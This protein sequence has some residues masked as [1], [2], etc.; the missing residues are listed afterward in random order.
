MTELLEQTTPRDLP[1]VDV[2]ALARTARR[3]T[4]RRRAV[5][6]TAAVAL[7]VAP[8]AVLT[9][10]RDEGSTGITTDPSGRIQPSDQ[11]EWHRASDPP[12]A[13]R[14][15]ALA[16]RTE[17]GRLVVW[18]GDTM[19]G[20]VTDQFLDGGVYD[21]ATDEWTAIAPAPLDGGPIGGGQTYRM[22]VADGRLAVLSAREVPDVAVY[23]LD[24]QRWIE[25]PPLD[26]LAV[27]WV[28]TMLWDGRDLALIGVPV[29][30]LGRE[31]AVTLRWT[32]GDADWTTGAPAPLEATRFWDIA[33][34]ASGTR[35]AAFTDRLAVYDLAADQ[36]VPAPDPPVG[37]RRG[38]SIA[39]Q[40][41]DV[42]VTSRAAARLDVAT[43]AWTALPE[44]PIRGW[45]VTR[46]DGPVVLVD[47]GGENATALVDDRWEP[48]PTFV[49]DQDCCEL[50]QAFS[51][52]L[53][54]GARLVATSE[55]GGNAGSLPFA[56]IVHQPGRGWSGSEPAP[57]GN[58][59]APATVL[60]GER[61]FVVGGQFGN[62]DLNPDVWVLD[63]SED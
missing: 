41:D 4:R 23:E 28:N 52:V 22:T 9:V 21:P 44:V 35:A 40:G 38:V 5:I 30:G 62:G 46:R 45:G 11:G 15:G 56:A 12:F 2:T 6:V 53:S 13:P 63:L 10:V 51:N 60:V 58:V 49:V 57:F 42:V 48:V 36:W 54:L 1:E 37:T 8:L 29:P 55:P 18:G 34:D 24:E 31:E 43:M 19:E 61:L 47:E 25:A 59:M 39:W 16:A 14:G 26:G 50:V 32:L 3:R 27:T 7:L 33:R 17:D 20:G